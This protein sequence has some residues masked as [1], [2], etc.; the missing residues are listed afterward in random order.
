MQ[1]IQELIVHNV[2]MLAIGST[3]LI[4]ERTT[5]I[6]LV[7]DFNITV[8]C[9]RG[10]ELIILSLSNL[11]SVRQNSHKIVTILICANQLHHFGFPP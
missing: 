7:G 6:A 5:T 10:D 2:A 8:L 9:E 1:S 11:S 3:A 4:T